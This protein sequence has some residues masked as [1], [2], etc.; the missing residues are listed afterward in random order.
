[1]AELAGGGWHLRT[2]PSSLGGRAS[3]VRMPARSAAA[4][5][6]HASNPSRDGRRFTSHARASVLLCTGAG[7]PACHPR[8]QADV[9]CVPAPCG[10]LMRRQI[11]EQCE[12]NHS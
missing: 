1:M 6:R 10:R 5:R 3:T 8:S 9:N 12:H 2:D 11:T 4:L 7:R